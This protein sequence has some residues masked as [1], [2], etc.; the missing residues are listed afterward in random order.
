MKLSSKKD[1][2][3]EILNKSKFITEG[4]DQLNERQKFNEL[5]LISSLDAIL[6]HRDDADKAVDIS[7]SELNQLFK[8]YL[9]I[10]EYKRLQYKCWYKILIF[11]F[12]I[13][14]SINETPEIVG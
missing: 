2:D 8:R 7:S 13:Y 1:S 9:Q 11:N 10:N 14:I 5:K 4:L 6:H 12:Y 3:Q